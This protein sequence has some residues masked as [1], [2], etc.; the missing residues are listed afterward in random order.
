MS[1]Y[2][3]AKLPDGFAISLRFANNNKKGGQQ[4]RKSG[5]KLAQIASK[6]SNDRFLW[7]NRLTL[8][9][10]ISGTKYDRDKL[11]FSAERGGQ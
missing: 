3:K 4:D 2:N 10:I 11:I 6:V 9:Q 7:K 8:C 1:I 5:R